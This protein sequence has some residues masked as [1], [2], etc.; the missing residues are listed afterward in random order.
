M[1][2]PVIS[3]PFQRYKRTWKEKAE[4]DV[5]RKLKLKEQKNYI[6]KTVN[7]LLTPK[8]RLNC[9]NSSNS[10][11]SLSV[12]MESE[13]ENVQPNELIE[14][15]FHSQDKVEIQNDIAFEKLS[16]DMSSDENTDESENRNKNENIYDNESEYGEMKMK[17][18]I[19]MI[20]KVQMKVKIEMKMN[21]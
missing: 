9:N 20:M 13:E 18:K 12:S 16:N 15:N 14:L 2:Y 4:R 17:I 19:D 3:H 7:R 8:C 1:F 6:L 11:R 5:K 10:N 21:T